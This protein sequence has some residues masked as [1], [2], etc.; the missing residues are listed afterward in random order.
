MLS[1]SCRGMNGGSR[2][3]PGAPFHAP[4]MA[5]A[6][7]CGSPSPPLPPATLARSTQMWSVEVRTGFYQA[8]CS[9]LERGIEP[10]TPSL[11]WSARRTWYQQNLAR[12]RDNAST[13]SSHPHSYTFSAPCAT[14]LPPGPSPCRPPIPRNGTAASLP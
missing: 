12:V 13:E 1:A 3:S 6:L 2:R 5:G 8:S 14:A 10:L 9:E 11:P 7:S 4:P